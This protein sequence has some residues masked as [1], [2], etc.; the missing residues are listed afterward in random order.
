MTP[1]R[2]LIVEDERV[3]ARDIESRLT[4]MGYAV[5]GVT[6]FGEEA[7]RLA[8]E[9]RP[10]LVLMDIR[11]KGA[12][13]GV[14]AAQEIRSRFQLP[15]VY[16]TAYADDD[17]LG[18]AR[19]T[20][21]FGY[22]LKPF[23]ERELQTAIEMALYKHRA[24]RELQESRH[25]YAVTLNSI[26]DAVI[27]TDRQGCVTFLNPVAEE[28]TGWRLAEAAGRPL[29]QVFRITN[30]ET[31]GPVEDP[32]ARVLRQGAVVGLAN[33]T[34][35]IRRDGKEVPIDDCGAPIRDDGGTVTGAVL[36]FHDITERRKAEEE[37]ARSQRRY[38]TLVNSVDG[39]VWEADARTFAFTF[40]SRQAERL[41]G[42]PTERWLTE[43][44]FWRDHIHLADREH[45]VASWH[46][47]TQEK[48]AYHLRYRMRAAQ[49]NEVWL[50]DRVNVVIENGVVVALRG[51]MVDIT[52]EIR[53][54]EQLRQALKMEAM[55]KLA[56]GVAHDFNNLITAIISYTDLLLLNLLPG[57]PL[58]SDLEEIKQAGWR[59]AAL[60]HQ[61]LAFGR[62]QVLQPVLLHLN[63]VVAGAARMLR[64]LIGEDVEL[65]TELASELQPV[66]ADRGQLEQVIVN[67]AVNARDAMPQGGRLTIATAD[68]VLG[69]AALAAHPDVPPGAYVQLRV[70]DT[71]SGMDAQ[72][73][74]QL[75]E[76]FFTTKEEGKGTGLGLAM[77]HGII[78]QS[79]GHIAVKSSLGQGTTFL[80]W[81]PPARR[82]QAPQPAAV[83]LSTTDL[84]QGKETVLLVEDEDAIRS[85][86]HR[87]LQESGYTVLDARHPGEALAVSRQ[88][89]GPI[90]LLLTD[91]VMPEMAGPELARRLAEERP[92]TRM[93]F[94]T[95]YADRAMAEL[96]VLD[97]KVR[98]LGK[99][100]DPLTLTQRVRDALGDPPAP[101]S[102]TPGSS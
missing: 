10:D 102:D 67:L 19:V 77:V 48:R 61:L 57:H 17:T 8:E 1:A 64:R 73:K 35:L 27:A 54:E 88:H 41:L 89:V 50:E 55:G 29:A 7:I 51:V 16:L 59:A 72:T 75:F 62:K 5:A 4:R 63:D 28:L 70:S 42:Y 2:I 37:R 97:R 13:D 76:P 32:V 83:A 44:T 18:R 91:V 100:F 31:R 43:P 12:M 66:K 74:A 56:G 95:G 69:E 58:R 34:V 101:S 79:G 93:L 46:T 94:M 20:E 40:V 15:V 68:V 65:V 30:E 82:E 96:K 99:P 38:E 90:H 25:R 71:G 21:P 36:V 87:I 33:H 3:V 60:A 98:V 47:A 52:Q 84:P 81:L 45:V 22:I 24:E 53:L 92:E 14:A 49:G 86:V 23:Q 39:I 9:R 85:L 26:G 78:K 80:I 11:L 6:R